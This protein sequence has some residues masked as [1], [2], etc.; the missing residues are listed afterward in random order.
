MVHFFLSL[1]SLLNYHSCEDFSQTFLSRIGIFAIFQLFPF[2]QEYL[3]QP[4]NIYVFNVRGSPHK[5]QSFKR[6]RILLVSVTVRTPVPC[7]TSICRMLSWHIWMNERGFRYF[8]SKHKTKKAGDLLRVCGQEWL[9]GP[10]SLTASFH[11][12]LCALDSA[13]HSLSCYPLISSKR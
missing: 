9:A 11:P 13:Y 4:E 6:I 1:R 10:E 8:T 2:L 3:S 7:I 12:A 5:K